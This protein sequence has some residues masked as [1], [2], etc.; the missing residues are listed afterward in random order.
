MKKVR[1]RLVLI[2][3]FM[4]SMSIANAHIHHDTSEHTQCIKCITHD[5]LDGGNA[6]IEEPIRFYLPHYN[7]IIQP[8]F[9]IIQERIYI[10]FD[11]RAPPF[12]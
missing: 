8:D 9:T 3:W 6:P 5:L 12:L 11:A 2:L 1:L 4:A 7:S 10:S